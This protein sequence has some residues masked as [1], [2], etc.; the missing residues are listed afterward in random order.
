VTQANL[1]GTH[2]AWGT[3]S[4]LVVRTFLLGEGQNLGSNLLTTI[5]NRVIARLKQVMEPDTVRLVDMERVVSGQAIPPAISNLKTIP[6]TLS[7]ILANTRSDSA[8]SLMTFWHS[9]SN[10]IVA[11]KRLRALLA[12]ADSVGY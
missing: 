3:T 7:I 10:N 9:T 2:P 5:S 1:R 12:S 6:T 11:L 4:P 8:N